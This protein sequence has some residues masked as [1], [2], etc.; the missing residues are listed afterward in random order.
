MARTGAVSVCVSG[1]GAAAEGW[2]AEETEAFTFGVTEGTERD[3]P[4]VFAAKEAVRSA[5]TRSS[6]LNATGAALVAGTPPG[7]GALEIPS[8]DGFC[9]RCGLAA[10]ADAGGTGKVEAAS[11]GEIGAE[12]LTEAESPVG[13]SPG[14]SALMTDG[15][16]L[17]WPAPGAGA[18][19]PARESTE[20]PEGFRGG[21]AVGA[22]WFAAKVGGWVKRAGAITGFPG[23]GATG[24]VAGTD[25][26]GS[27]VEVN[28][29]GEVEAAAGEATAAPESVA[30]ALDG[31]GKDGV[32]VGRIGATRAAAEAESGVSGAVGAKAVGATVTTG[33]TGSVGALGETTGTTDGRAAKGAVGLTIGAVG[34]GPFA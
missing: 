22:V 5:T 32:G 2:D 27:H 19:K 15:A 9:S 10:L 7:R 11:A 25:G 1:V 13:G 8:A 4:D 17:A 30:G 31:R 29:E 21:P 18:L 20:K 3:R 14:T 26:A 28:S 12:T 23:V 24:G 34:V 16:G 33:V 6:M